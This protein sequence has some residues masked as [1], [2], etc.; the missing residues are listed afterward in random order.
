MKKIG[1]KQAWREINI[2]KKKCRKRVKKEIE[3]IK[4]DG[5]KKKRTK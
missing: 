1:M 4:G 2:R 5:N 3:T